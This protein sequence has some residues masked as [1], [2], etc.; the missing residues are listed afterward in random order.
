MN[1]AFFLSP[2]KWYPSGHAP[3]PARY[4]AM[5]DFTRE[6]RAR[7]GDWSE[8]RRGDVAVVRVRASSR[9]IR[10][11]SKVS[12]FR[13]LSETGAR[14]IAPVGR[15][16]SDVPESVSAELQALKGR[17]AGVGFGLGWRLPPWLVMSLALTGMPPIDGRWL[18]PF[19]N[20]IGAF[21]TTGILATFTTTE[22]PLSEGGN[23]TNPLYNGN[24]NLEATGGQCK[25]TNAG[26]DD[27][28]YW[29]TTTFGP[30]CEIYVDVA[31]AG[32]DGNHN[33]TLAIR[34][35]DPGLTTLDGHGCTF[36]SGTTGATNGLA[37]VWEHT[38][39]SFTQIGADIE[40]DITNGVKTG[41][42]GV[43]GTLGIYRNAGS[44][45][46]EAT[47]AA[48]YTAAGNIGIGIKD[49]TI[50]LDNMGGGTVITVYRGMSEKTLLRPR[51]FAPSGLGRIFG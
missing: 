14:R 43:G 51:P 32:A 1:T 38:N 49:T 45:V 11:L 48:V 7:G 44:W 13:P 34:I 19:F 41:Y 47:R 37:Q 27:S 31:T 12:A 30:N 18:H 23:F 46:Q 15:M 5:N 40:M 9:M 24:G 3:G 25:A 8:V 21:P 20:Q 4:C 16:I 6:I 22:N 36:F 28:A 39:G 33:N 42:D 2:Y 17:W 35:V 29:D 26:G 10:S 50:R